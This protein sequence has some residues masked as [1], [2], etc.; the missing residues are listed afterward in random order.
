MIR[1]LLEMCGYLFG[2]VIFMGVLFEVLSRAITTVAFSPAYAILYAALV[3]LLWRAIT[4][5]TR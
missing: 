5:L 3:V 4:R 2:C 1:L